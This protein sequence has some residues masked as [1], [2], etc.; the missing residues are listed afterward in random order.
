MEARWAALAVLTAARASMG[1]EFQSL[2]SVAPPLMAELG[3][4]YA[5]LGF[6]IGLFFLP[7]IALALPG[8]WLGQRFGDKRVVLAGLALMAGGGALAG[9]AEGHAALL[10]GR[11]LSGI[12]AV[13]LN[14]VMAKMVTDWFAGREIVLA[15]AVFVN[16]F[17]IGVGLALALLGAL[18]EAAGWRLALQAAAGA[19]LAS[20]LLVALLYRPHAN[21]GRA[22]AGAAASFTRRELALV[23]IAGAI[24]GIYNGVFA[25][26][27]GFV[28]GLLVA[29]GMS[30]AAAGFLLGLATWLIVASVQAGGMIAQRWGFAHSLMLLGIGACALCLLALPWAPPIPVLV[31]SGLL[32]GLPIGVIM[33]LPAS[34]LRPASRSIGMGVFYTWLYAGHAGLPPLAGWLQDLWQGEPAAP[35]L[36]AGAATLTILPLYAGFLR[37]RATVA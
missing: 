36:F 11:L 24:W 26:M 35:V 30:G 21:D 4:G 13:L 29:R 9:A 28:P 32:Q 33:A 18:A 22:A 27:T 8:G 1:F 12:G 5:E 10:A 3:L 16:S 31:A 2:A 25:I 7:G 20:L 6:L 14:V 15:M 34:A 37:C 17:P 23:C 19:A